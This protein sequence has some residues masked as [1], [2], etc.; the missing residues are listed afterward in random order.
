MTE[1]LGI[2]LG[3]Y[4]VLAPLGAGGMGDVYRARDTRLGREV[5]VKVLPPHLVDSAEA[6]ARFEREARAVAAISHPNILA[7]HDVGQDGS[8]AYAVT[9]LLEGRTLRAV[10]EEGGLSPRRALEIVAQAARGL[11][12]AHERGIVHRDIKPENLFLTSDGRLK[13]LDFGVATNIDTRETTM[14]AAHL[15]QPGTLVGTPMYMAPEQ[16]TGEAATPRSDLFALAIVAHE[17]LSGVHPFKRAT[18][19]ETIGAILRHDPAPLGPSAAALPAGAARVLAQCLEKPAGDRPES[20]RDLAFFLDTL[21]SAPGVTASG[22]GDRLHHVRRIVRRRVFVASI[23]TTLLMMGA[24]LMYAALV[25]QRTTA[26]SSTGDFSRVR[27]VAGRVQD[28]RLARVALAASLIASFPTLKAALGTDA[29]T[30]RDFL[31][32]QQTLVAGEPTLIATLPDGRVLARTDAATAAPPAAGDTWVDTLLANNRGPAVVTIDGRLHHAARAAVEAGGTTFGHVVVAM[33]IGPVFARE[34]SD[35][36]EEEVVLL[37]QGM[38]GATVRDEQTPWRSADEW[39]AAGGARNSVLPVAIGGRRVDA[40]EVALSA[41]PPLVAVLA[42]PHEEA[43]TP[44]RQLQN[45]LVMLAMIGVVLAA[46]AAWWS[47]RSA[48][49][50]IASRTR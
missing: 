10:I 3:P 1:L 48:A 27:R 16:L 6:L 38:V 13:I 45:G 32:H 33:P 43:P 35:A 20:A 30:V 14:A 50:A 34:L 49:H 15:T 25:A 22:D 9:E 4:E 19:S 26:G 7:L 11:G 23:A 31:L 5:A 28:D 29:A 46:A 39:R 40:H 2:R 44:F 18:V 36:T 21:A 37:S 17:L 24:L 41:E 12:A 47:A 8:I 42:R